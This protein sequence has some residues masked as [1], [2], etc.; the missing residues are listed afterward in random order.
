ME[1]SATIAGAVDNA[2]PQ[3]FFNPISAQVPHIGSIYMALAKPPN[4]SVIGQMELSA[5]IAGAVDNASPQSF[6]NPISAQVPH[7]GSI[8]MAL[9]KPP[10]GS[11]NGRTEP[12]A[13]TAGAVARSVK[14]KGSQR[15]RSGVA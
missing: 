10:N 3:S 2:S 12:S 13:N 7:I 14:P 11:I 8:Y 5:T 6:F 1:P 9:A 15:R 4:G